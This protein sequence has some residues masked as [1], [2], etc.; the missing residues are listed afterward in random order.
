MQPFEYILPEDHADASR[1]LAAGADTYAYQGGTDLLVGVRA[2]AVQPTRVVDLKALPRMQEIRRHDDG[3]LVIGAACTMNS[4]A[5]HPEVVAGFRLLAD[6]CTS[7]AT[8]GIRNR[9]TIGG[10]VCNASPAADV[11]PALLCMDA[12][13]EIYGP[14]GTRRVAMAEFF[15]GPGQHCLGLGEFLTS[16]QICPLPL[17]AVG[18]FNKLGRTKIGDI[19]VASV[20]V[21]AWPAERGRCWRIAMGAVAPTPMRASEAEAALAADDSPQGVSRAVELVA[22]AARPIDDV[23]A[24]GQYRRAMVK[25]LARRAIESVMECLGGA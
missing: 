10:N 16:I 24:S 22:K 8:Y 13:A 4:I 5:Q 14:T 25:V 3:A 1:L 6:A 12:Q 7:V 21:L 9:A 19:S 23:R 20:A 11:A 2:G 15:L 18:V 17:R